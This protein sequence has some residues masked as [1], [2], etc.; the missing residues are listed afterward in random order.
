MVEL[1]KE[2]RKQELG[3]AAYACHPSTG[4]PEEED[5]EFQVSL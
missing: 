2:E 4:R 1:L 5:G 3:M